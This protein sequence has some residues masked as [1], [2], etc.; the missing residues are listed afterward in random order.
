MPDYYLENPAALMGKPKATIADYVER[1]G[2]LVP[3]RYATLDDALASGVPII[4]RSEH[5]Q[6]Y[7]GV[8]GLLHSPTIL[9]GQ[10]VSEAELLA[11]IIA[12]TPYA[13]YCRLTETPEQ[14]FLSEI[15]FSLWEIVSGYNTKIVADTAIKGR[16][17]I[18]IVSPNKGEFPY[19]VI[20]EK[21]KK[22]NGSVNVDLSIF[23]DS[24]P[25]LIEMYEQVRR[26]D[27]FDDKNCPVMEIQ[28]YQGKFYFLQKL[29]AAHEMLSDFELNRN[30][31]PNEIAATYV[32]GATKQG[33]EV[34]RATVEYAAFV[35]DDLRHE[36]TNEV[37]CADA[38]DKNN[39]IFKE[40]MLSRQRLSLDAITNIWGALPFMFK[41]HS[42]ASQ[43]FKP[44]ISL[45]VEQEDWNKIFP[46]EDFKFFLEKAKSTGQDQAIDLM[47][48]SDGRKAY[49]SRV[50]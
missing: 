13:E 8:S 16:Y 10:K 6:D 14:K 39:N 27:R 3:R 22:V 4:A 36:L 21:G 37:A 48:V 31:N 19:Y 28:F 46:R 1:N 38:R 26:L 9:P 49:I 33:G 42:L 29:V 34:F 50:N 18:S 47:V 20:I 17:H 11:Q 44:E 41:G 12:R 5:P 15:S 25:Q 30:Q 2:I 35:R 32:R 7:G 45:V 43:F 24:L 23:G 40:L